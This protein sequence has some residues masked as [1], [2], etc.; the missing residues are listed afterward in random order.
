MPSLK[1]V[2]ARIAD[3]KAKILPDSI[4]P[5]YLGTI[6]E[7]MLGYGWSTDDAGNYTFNSLKVEST[8]SVPELIFDHYSA[9]DVDFFLTERDI[10]ENVIDNGDGTYTLQF[11]EM[12]PGYFTEQIENNILK[13]TYNDIPERIP[14]GD[15]PYTITDPTVI[16]SW[17][18]ILSVD[19]AAN[20]A[21]VR[22]YSDAEISEDHNCLPCPGM[23]VMRVG[24]S[25]DSSN[26]R[27]FQ[28]QSC[29]YMAG[30]DGRI[31]KLFRVTKPIIDNGMTAVS[32]GTIPDF[33][34]DLD[35]RLEPGDDG[36]VADTVVA[37]RF[38]TVDSIGRPVA[39]TI[40]RGPWVLGAKFYDGSEPN[41]NGIYERS[42]AYCNG[43][44]WLNNLG[45]IATL[46]NKPAWNS[47]FWTHAIGDTFLRLDFCEKDCIIDEDDPLCP[48]SV[49]A[50]YMGEDVTNSPAIYYNWE[51]VSIRDG[52]EDTASDSMWNERHRN[53]GPSL[54]L[55]GDDLNFQ[56]GTKPDSV[57]IIVTAILHDPNNP[58]LEPEQAE[59]Y[60]I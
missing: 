49:H 38:I 33:I 57:R 3:L 34:T 59:Q 56:F 60:L 54:I 58:K 55:D 45:G 6:L 12:Y 46:E 13:G 44:G 10:I 37:R 39:Q 20:T 53:A 47:T 40:D 32:I 25:G 42:L 9:I 14:E 21:L 52:L 41:D 43:H 8:L 51:R 18:N 15:P 24:N 22:L 19:A 5:H 1:Q 11:R 31:V 48:M 30:S 7:Q 29:L 2:L 27:Y 36:V 23:K 26:P 35:P 17:M 28:R 4:S 16:T 50:E